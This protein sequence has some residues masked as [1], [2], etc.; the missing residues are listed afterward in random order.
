[1]RV[2][3]V[4]RRT[5]C[6]DAEARLDDAVDAIVSSGCEALP[7]V[8]AHD[9]EVVVRQFVTVRDLPKLRRAEASAGRGHAI[10]ASVLELLSALGRGPA[11][12]PT[13]GSEA[14]LADAWGMMADECLTHLPVLEEDE[15]VGIVSLVVSFSEFPHRS[16]AAGFW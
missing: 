9:G 12:L 1:M 5:R 11:R 4:M 10:G 16:P 2:R 6:L 3:D 7:I 15:V 14:T 13:I 8:D